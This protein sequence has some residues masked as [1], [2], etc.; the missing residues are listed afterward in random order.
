MQLFSIVWQ[1]TAEQP[2]KRNLHQLKW[3]CNGKE[4]KGIASAILCGM[5]QYR[6]SVGSQMQEPTAQDAVA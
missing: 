4:E 3:E 2:L 6:L 1:H 5:K